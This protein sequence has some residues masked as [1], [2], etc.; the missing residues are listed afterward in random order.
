MSS[1]KKILL[2]YYTYDHEYTNMLSV[3]SIGFELQC[4]KPV[5]IEGINICTCHFDVFE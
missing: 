3:V 5:E 2:L 1:Q 4:H